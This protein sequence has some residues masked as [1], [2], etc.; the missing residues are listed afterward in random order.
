MDVA[1]GALKGAVLEELHRALDKLHKDLDELQS[2]LEELQR[3]WGA[4]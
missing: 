2:A 4:A 1:R 3:A